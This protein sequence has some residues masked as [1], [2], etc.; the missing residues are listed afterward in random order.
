MLPYRGFPDSPGLED[1][2]EGAERRP[3]RRRLALGVPGRSPVPCHNLEPL[4][5][6]QVRPQQARRGSCRGRTPALPDLEPDTCVA[7]A[8]LPLKTLIAET[9]TFRHEITVLRR[10]LGPACP[11]FLVRPGTSV[12]PGQAPA[13]QAAPP[14]PR[15]PCHASGLAPTPDHRV[16]DLPEPAC[17]PRIDSELRD[18]IRLARE[19]S[20]WGHRRIQGEL[21]RLGRHRIG[22]GTIRSILTATRLGPA[23]RGTDTHWRALLRAQAA[24]LLATDFFHLDTIGLRRLYVL[25]VMEIACGCPKPCTQPL[26]CCF[27][28]S[29]RS[30]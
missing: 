2:G 16:M 19:N 10:R 29:W 6:L 25:F 1:R 4:P 13:P 5:D 18:L 14:P 9:L 23:P 17:R 28:A 8:A 15:H 7:C 27:A 30:A 20:R 3:D 26:T 22:T 24:W 21:T 12:R 11:S